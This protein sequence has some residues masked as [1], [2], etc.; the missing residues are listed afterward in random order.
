MFLPHKAIGGIVHSHG[1]AGRGNDTGQV[2]LVSAIITTRNRP[3]LLERAVKSIL[4]QTYPNIE[5]IIV[6]DAS[7]DHT[8]E[9]VEKYKHCSSIEI[10][11]LRQSECFGA[12]AARNLGISKANGKFI[13]GLDDDDEWMP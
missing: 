10:R 7:T 1:A 4:C 3:Q 9:L 11:Y 8:P 12:P 2:P 13:A 6:D 5:I